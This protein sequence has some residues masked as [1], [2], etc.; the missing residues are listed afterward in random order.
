MLLNDKAIR[1]LCVPQPLQHNGPKFCWGPKGES[2]LPMIEPFSE[3]VSGNGVISYGLSHAGYDLRLGPKV[4]IY[5]NTRGEVID[6]KRFSDPDYQRRLLEEVDL[7]EVWK[8][9]GGSIAVG[10]PPNGYIL[11]YSLEYLRIPRHLK[12]RCV[13]K[14]TLARCGIIC[15]TTPLEPGWCGHLTIELANA[16]PCPVIVYVGEGIAQM[17]LETLTDL[18]EQDYAQKKGKYQEQEDAPMPAKVL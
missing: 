18:P 8:M 17:E 15:N 13:G 7:T 9:K 6:P 5:T 14:S 12:G 2:I 11:G 1:D 4:L 10:I 3:A 16:T